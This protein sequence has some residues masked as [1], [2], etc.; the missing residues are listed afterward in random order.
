MTGRCLATHLGPHRALSHPATDLGGRRVVYK[1]MACQ[2]RWN[3][4]SRYCV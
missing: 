4:G 3:A 1:Q 2:T